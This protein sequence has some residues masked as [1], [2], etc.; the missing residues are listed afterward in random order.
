M[1]PH[2]HLRRGGP[3]RVT[4][5]RALGL[6]K[7]YVRRGGDAPP[8]PS[9][10][11]EPE[12]SDARP[13]IKLIAGQ[14]PRI[15]SDIE[16]AVLAANR[17]LFNRGGQ[18]VRIGEI[19]LLD[20][21]EEKIRALAII[22]QSEHALLEDAE[23]SA[24][25]VKYNKRER[26][27]LPADP[28]LAVIN[29]WQ[30]RKTRSRLPILS[31]IISTPL[32]LKTG[33]IIDKPGLDIPTGFFFN[34][35]ETVF[36]PVPR[37]PTRQD[38][39]DAL[40]LLEHLLAEFEFVD[41]PS[42]A[43]AL[44]GILTS[45]VRRA[46]DFAFM[47]AVT[48]PAYGTGKSCLVNLFCMIASG[49]TAPV[50]SHSKSDEE[51]EKRLDGRL[52]TGIGHLAIDNVSRP[53]G[54]DKLSQILTEKQL[55]IRPLGTSND[56][57]VQPTIFV[58]ATGTNIVVVEDLRRRTLLCSMDAKQERPE[59][60]KFTS[61]P[62]RLVME[63]RG[64][65]VCAALTIIGAF[66]QSGEGGADPINGYA[67][68]CRMVRDPLVWLGCADPCATMETIR[69]QDTTLGAK[70][71]VGQ[72]WKAILG[73][74]PKTAL[75]VILEASKRNDYDNNSLVHPEFYEALLEIARDGR[76]SAPIG[77]VF[78]CAKTRVTSSR[79]WSLIRS[80]LR[81]K[82]P[83]RTGLRQAKAKIAKAWPA[84]SLNGREK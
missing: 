69:K 7:P 78:G 59:L 6:I 55:T 76:H 27:W 51:F 32:I 82:K 29:T 68:Y 21:D 4:R 24:H 37:N 53:I 80:R 17:G 45:V 48:S 67:C 65:I 28:S 33:R 31:G 20:A 61:D 64:E 39:L 74:E 35:L 23:A 14:L 73:N 12:D 22:V 10:P 60:R 13:V 63:K 62:L 84:G 3:H 8:P 36:P 38:A 1:T 49:R 71:Q 9:G 66:M 56:T 41:K 40:D 25:F 15:V 18:I 77:S 54:G 44:S 11:S 5:E 70:I 75:Q 19:E 83:C 42:H 34:P 47:H 16:E 43:V 52:L 81:L 26:S 72:Q 46:L 57:I 30:A 50:I 79:L 58:T 2:L